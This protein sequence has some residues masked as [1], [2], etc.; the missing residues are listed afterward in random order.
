MRRLI[1]SLESMDLKGKSKSILFPT[2]AHIISI[3]GFCSVYIWHIP[4]VVKFV[5][6]HILREP[7]AIKQAYKARLF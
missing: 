5:S 2:K 6:I 7:V 1:V 4:L 3:D